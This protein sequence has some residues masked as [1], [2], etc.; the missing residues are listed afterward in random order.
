MALKIKTSLVLILFISNLFASSSVDLF[1][2]DKYDSNYFSSTEISN[3]ELHIGS[4]LFR[5]IE[6]EDLPLFG[7]FI[8]SFLQK[9]K[10]TF[11]PNLSFNNDNTLAIQLFNC[12]AMKCSELSELWFEKYNISWIKL[13]KEN[14]ELSKIKED[15]SE[16]MI[17]KK[18]YTDERFRPY[19][20]TNI[21]NNTLLAFIVPKELSK[22][23]FK[24]SKI[25]LNTKRYT[26]N[27]SNFN[28]T[29]IIQ[30]ND[31]EK[32]ELVFNFPSFNKHTLL[33][34]SIS[35]HIIKRLLSEDKH[36]SVNYS[37]AQSFIKYFVKS[38]STN[39]KNFNIELK[40]IVLSEEN[41]KQ[42]MND[43][44]DEILADITKENLFFYS[45][46]D[47]LKLE[48][49]RYI[50]LLEDFYKEI[51]ILENKSKFIVELSP[52]NNLYFN[53]IK[54][55]EVHHSS[56]S[57]GINF[58][59]NSI[60][61][62]NEED[63]AL[64]PKLNLFLALNQNYN[65]SIISSSKKSEYLFIEKSKKEAII[66][67]YKESGY[68]ISNSKKLK[69]YRSLIIFN[70]LIN[71]NTVATRLNCIGVQR[72]FSRVDFEFIMTN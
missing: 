13:L 68:I 65:L 28:Y 36:I 4:D 42:Y 61:F 38:D 9:E 48:Q 17:L 72:K 22:N 66:D 44:I 71:L 25:Y 40:N 59:S 29:E 24:R 64:I 54:L 62:V 31:L 55:N 51:K 70:D 43:A 58:K 49:L 67:K 41:F 12:N 20:V 63:T 1:F 5:F 7:N 3:T 16:I 27:E 45:Y 30:N 52:N 47:K 39:L 6:N 11:D 50:Y 10:I 46:Y 23:E 56:F 33:K 26:S 69:L 18:I 14:L 53:D 2:T 57:E 32:N 34:N 60:K 21:V 8:D 35:V 15:D 37:I 19:H